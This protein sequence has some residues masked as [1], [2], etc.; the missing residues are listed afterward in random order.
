MKIM[1]SVDK[2]V[3]DTTYFKY[4]INL[5]KKIVEDSKFEGKELEVIFDNGKI[6]IKKE[7]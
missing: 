7:K 3:G 4:K 1:K 6:L 5:P 2:K